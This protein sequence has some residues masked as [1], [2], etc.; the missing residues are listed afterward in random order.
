MRIVVPRETAADERRVAITP[1]VVKRLAARQVEVTMQRGAGC[2]AQIAD[3]DYLAAGARIEVDVGALWRN[4]EVVVKVRAPSPSEAALLREGAVV[5]AMLQ[6]LA[7]VE[8][9][10]D[11][12]ARRIT[13]L[14]ADMV[15]RTTVAQ[16][17]DVLSSQASIAGYRAVL[18]AAESCPRLFPLMM[19]AAGTISPARVLVLGAGVAGLQAIAT[20]R[21]LGAVVEAFDVRKVV[22]EQVESLGAKF[23]EVPA[24]E[25]GAGAGGYA[26]EVSADYRRRQSE[27]I[28]QCLARAD[29]CITTAQVPGKR[30]PTLIEADQ[31]RGMRPGSVIVDLAA[32]QGGN[33]ELARAGQRLCTPN[34]VLIIGDRN[35]PSQAAV[36]ASQLYARNMDKLLAHLV[37]DGAL[38]VDAADEICGPMIICRDGAIVHPAIAAAAAAAQEVAA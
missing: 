37:R 9:M 26:K 21:R 31:V 19:T 8:L 13:A 16:M 32:E 15:P 10:R 17:M 23:I 14:A 12:A 27:L 11:L 30:A 35:L 36:H 18:L 28:G 33:C 6:P 38:A 29:I 22:K 4:A 24:D 2:A 1:E 3:A 20:A 5:I 7:E 34:G 25:D